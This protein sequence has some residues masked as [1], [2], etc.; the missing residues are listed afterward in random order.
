MQSTISHL[1]DDGVGDASVRVQKVLLGFHFYHICNILYV[2]LYLGLFVNTTL[3]D[4]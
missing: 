3:L 2:I 1:R 4:C